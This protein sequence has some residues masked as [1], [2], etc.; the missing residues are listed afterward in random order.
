[1]YLI[2]N[3]KSLGWQQCMVSSCLSLLFT[4]PHVCWHLVVVQW[5]LSFYLSAVFW[6]VFAFEKFPGSASWFGQ[7]VLGEWCACEGQRAER[8]PGEAPPA[9]C[10][11]LPRFLPAWRDGGGIWRVQG[12]CVPPP[13]FLVLGATHLKHRGSLQ[14]CAGLIVC[15]LKRLLLNQS[16]VTCLEEYVPRKRFLLRVCR[17]VKNV[18]H[19]AASC[20]LVWS[21]MIPNMTLCQMD[22]CWAIVKRPGCCFLTSFEQTMDFR[23]SSHR[24]SKLLPKKLQIFKI[25]KSRDFCPKIELTA[26]KIR[27]IIFLV[28]VYI[29]RSGPVISNSVGLAESTSIETGWIIDNWGQIKIL[30]DRMEPWCGIP[31]GE[32]HWG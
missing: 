4:G 25:Q 2:S 1:M 26:Q 7:L 14:C 22:F 18:D 11:F 15:G 3:T 8:A 17:V 27:Q 5:V 24:F 21:E 31:G 10:P 9:F 19:Q 32:A 29:K 6:S 28:V 20:G 12:T 30:E 13:L 23:K 16:N